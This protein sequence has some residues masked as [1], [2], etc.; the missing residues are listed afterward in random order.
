MLDEY[1][2]FQYQGAEETVQFFY[3]LNPASSIFQKFLVSRPWNL[4]KPP[5]SDG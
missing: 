1:T 2:A 5:V 4:N 3:L